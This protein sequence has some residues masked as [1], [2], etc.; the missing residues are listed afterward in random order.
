M[1]SHI[2][3]IEFLT[4][5]FCAGAD[6]SKAELRAPSIRGELHWWFRCLGA[7]RDEETSIFGGI[8][9]NQPTASSF[10]VRIHQQPTGGDEEWH[11]KIK[12]TG[13]TSD[14]YLLGFFCGRTNRLQRKGA[15]A[16]GSKAAIQLLFKQPPTPR[17]E[18][19][20][21]VFFSIGAVGFRVTRAAGA[22]ASQEHALVSASWT[23]LQ[24]ELTSA[25]FK[26]CLLGDDFG[27]DWTAVIRKA[28]DLLKNKL[29]SN[30]KGLG[31]PS[32]TASPLGSAEPR[33]KSAVYLRPVRIDGRL[34][35]A[36]IEAPHARVLGKQALSLA[37]ET[38]SIVE[39]LLQR[40]LI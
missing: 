26:V 30:E 28:G 27:T 22:F 16:P 40:R 17:L 36:L 38:T 34:R 24:K 37:R 15:I 19:T 6:P 5:C 32:T 3:H 12:R 31:I 1:I 4:P 14:A 13:G 11:N 33:Q 39:L 7:T 25:G 35:L 20:L 18:K 29:R 9:G 23:D 21:R 8:H 2:Y 10:M